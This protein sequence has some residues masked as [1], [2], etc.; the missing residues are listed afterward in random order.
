MQLKIDYIDNV[1]SLTELPNI[2][3]RGCRSALMD[4][5]E[6]KPSIKNIMKLL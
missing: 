3:L 5:Q 4:K 2:N 1:L 6:A